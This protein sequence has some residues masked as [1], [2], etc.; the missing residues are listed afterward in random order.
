M[1]LK[2]KKQRGDMGRYALLGRASLNLNHMRPIEIIITTHFHL[3]LGQ[4]I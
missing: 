2:I 4:R 1:P 3:L